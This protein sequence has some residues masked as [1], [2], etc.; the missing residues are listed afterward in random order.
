LPKQILAPLAPARI[1]R[2]RR[3]RLADCF[4]KTRALRSLRGA[5]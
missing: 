3:D 2:H 5:R 4:T 1:A